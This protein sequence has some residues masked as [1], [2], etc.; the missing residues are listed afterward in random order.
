M[1][2]WLEYWQRR[3]FDFCCV[4]SILTA[5][6]HVLTQLCFGLSVG[7][8]TGL[9]GEPGRHGGGGDHSLEG[10]FPLLHVELRVEDDDVDF[11]HVEQAEGDRGAQVHGDGERGGLNVELGSRKQRFSSWT[12]PLS[13]KTANILMRQ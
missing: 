3:Q 8:V 13:H 6:L 1:I 9:V 12:K 7:P 4:L 5:G 10:S 2:L 11:G